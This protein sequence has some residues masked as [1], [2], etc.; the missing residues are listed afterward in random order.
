M[1]ILRRLD[2]IG[3]ASD[4]DFIAWVELSSAPVF[5]LTI[6]EHAF[7]LQKRFDLSPRAHQ[8]NQLEELTQGNVRGID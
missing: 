3:L 1:Y 6:H 8:V 7:L 5:C 4:A 2:P